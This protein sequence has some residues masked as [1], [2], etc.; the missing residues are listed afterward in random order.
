MAIQDLSQRDKF[1][2]RDPRFWHSERMTKIIYNSMNASISKLCT[3]L[4]TNPFMK[5]KW[6]KINCQQK[7]EETS[8][9]C[10]T[11]TLEKYIIPQGDYRISSCNYGYVFL[12]DKC[13][14]IHSDI[15]YSSKCIHSFENQ[16]LS[17]FLTAW[18]RFK[19]DLIIEKCI[20]DCRIFETKAIDIQEVKVW[21]HYRG[22]CLNNT[23]QL[24][25][26]DPVG[27]HLICTQQQ[28]ECSDL[29]CVSLAYVCDGTPDC[30]DGKDEYVCSSRCHQHFFRCMSG[31]CI[32]WNGVC[33]GQQNCEDNSDELYCPTILDESLRIRTRCKLKFSAINIHWSLCSN[34]VSLNNTFPSHLLCV[35]E[36]DLFG[37]PLYCP[38]TEHLQFCS[39]HQCPH[40]FKC[41]DSHC[42]PL[43]HVCDKIEDCPRGK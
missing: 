16:D 18:S 15:L 22:L 11:E 27:T 12:K 23:L 6:L 26:V 42:I 21:K 36:R 1:I 31:H 2:K 8:F 28:F 38:T 39:T 37:K 7:F 20:G 5:R 29:S 19:T 33:D 25:I 3:L 40:M 9:I 14:R 32:H 17:R 43:H 34:D 30:K 10:E 35:F 13:I 41:K 4:L 24:S